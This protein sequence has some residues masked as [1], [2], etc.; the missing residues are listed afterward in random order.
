M[1]DEI[2]II[3]FP[4]PVRVG[5]ESPIPEAVIIDFQVFDA[6]TV[7]R[8]L[9]LLLPTAAAMQPTAEPVAPHP[10]GETTNANPT[11]L[12]LPDGSFLE[13]AADWIQ[14]ENGHYARN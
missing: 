1:T 9:T 8:P 3:L 7:G 12:Y 5:D 14:D 2:T 13:L 4:D 6:I 10:E 11:R